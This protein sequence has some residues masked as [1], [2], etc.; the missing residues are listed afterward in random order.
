M[1]TTDREKEREKNTSGNELINELRM[2]TG[3]FLVF[4]CNL[5]VRRNQHEQLIDS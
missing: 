1:K 4:R 5:F 2:S 3:Y